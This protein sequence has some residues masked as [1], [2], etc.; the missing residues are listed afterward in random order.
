M[1]PGLIQRPFEWHHP[2]DLQKQPHLQS[3][4]S[5][6]EVVQL[7]LPPAFSAHQEKPLPASLGL[8]GALVQASRTSEG[9]ADWQPGFERPLLISQS[10]QGEGGRAKRILKTLTS[11]PFSL[12]CILFIPKSTPLLSVIKRVPKRLW[13]A[14]LHPLAHPHCFDVVKQPPNIDRDPDPL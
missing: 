9:H 14:S 3:A 11:G 8:L 4:M 13:L 2:C 6:A 7:P 5:Q 12:S 10:F 1:S